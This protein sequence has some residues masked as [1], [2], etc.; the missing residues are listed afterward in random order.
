MSSTNS[1]NIMF[2]WY[3]LASP[4]LGHQSVVLGTVE[5]VTSAAA[6]T[7][8]VAGGVVVA[9]TGVVTRWCRHY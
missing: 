3:T 8:V 6:A 2:L 1:T 5:I 4:F 7:V 9:S